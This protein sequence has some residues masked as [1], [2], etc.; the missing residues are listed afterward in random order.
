MAQS[1]GSGSR[2]VIARGRAIRALIAALAVI[3]SAAAVVSW[4]I[5]PFSASRRVVRALDVSSPFANTRPE[6]RY[7]GDESCARCHAE[8]AATYRRHPM[9]RSLATVAAAGMPA[10]DE[11]ADD[12]PL[13]EADGLEYSIERRDGRVFHRETRR[14]GSGRVVAQN[15][16][17]VQYM[18]GSGNQGASFLIDRDGFVFQS[19]ISWYARQRRWDLSPG[20]RDQNMH[21]DR[22]VTSACL[23]CHANRVE[24]VEGAVNRYKPPTFR[25]GAIGC[26][27]CHGPGEL[28]VRRP[29]AASG[30]EPTIVN[31]AAL[32][33][34][35]RDAVCE[36]CHLMGQQRVVK[37]DRLEDD[38]RPGLPFDLVWSVFERAEGAATEKFVGHVEQ[39]HESRCYRAS[40]GGL[41][42]ISCHDPHRQPSAEERAGYY[43]GRCLECHAESRGCR[44][45]EASRRA[46]SRDDDC[47]ACHM[48][49]LGQS[50]IPHVAATDY[51]IPREPGAADRSAGGVG[52]GPRPGDRPLVPFRRD[53]MD[54]RRRAEAER[55]LGVAL[56]RLGAQADAMALP[57]LDRALRAHPDDLAAWQAK[58]GVLGRLGAFARGLAAYREALDRQPDFESAR[59]GAADIQ[60]RLGRRAEAIADWRR[61]IAL[62][63]WRAAY[64]ANLAALCFEEHDWRGAI[65]ACRDALRL[66]PAD[67]ESRERLV[68][69]L[70]HLDDRE[71]ARE[72][73]RILLAF[74]PSDRDA[75][76]RRFPAISP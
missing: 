2:S 66:D 3:G 46:R 32:E 67:L 65:A 72:E 38:F 26:E 30:T 14:D 19:P 57:L 47:T 56:S 50:D 28:H 25:G 27:R 40:S 13:F 71:A 70:L 62:N 17:E 22:V 54:D 35:L 45:P 20:Y 44:L 37:L 5:A 6:V 24:A 59:T 15:E 18:L 36:Q 61:A 64:R 68:A 53:G 63:P 60:A 41:G 11:A 39:M 8:I 23:Y 31:P 9:G 73:L 52:A 74:N 29:G 55:D 43:R 42:C 58:G 34:G 7:V 76:I 1:M 75:L 48:P 51:R 10:L 69:A 49:R 12:R 33:P 21:F 4:Q 16:A